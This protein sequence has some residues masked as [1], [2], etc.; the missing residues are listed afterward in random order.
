MRSAVPRIVWTETD[1]APM[2][3]TYSFLPVVKAFL[4]HGGIKVET[5]DISLAG[6]ILALFPEL[7]PE[8]KRVSDDLA[9][10]GELVSRSEANIIKLPN[11]SASVPQLKAAIR[12]LQEKGFKIPD[13][14][15]EAKTEEE[16]QLKDRYAKVLG[17]AVNPVLRQG[18]ADRR[19]PLAVKEYAK[20]YPTAMGLPLKEW[21]PNSKCHVAHMDGNDFYGNEKS[22]TVEK[23]TT[24]RIELVDESGN[25]EI[26]KENLQ[27]TEG[28]V[29]DGTFMSVKALRKFY[30]AQIE[31]A[32]RQG[33]LL[34][35]HLKATMMKVSDPVLFGHAVMVYFREVFEKY[36]DVFEEIGV[37]PNNGL[38]DLYTK[39]QKLP[40]DKRKEIEGAIDEVYKKNPELA[41]VDSRKG[42]TNLHMPNNI[43]IDAS[44]PVVIRDGGK[45]WGPDDKLHDTKAMIPDRSY[46]G[47]YKET[48]EDCKRR[49]AFDRSTMGSVSNVGL[50]A[51]KAEEYG[52]HDKTFIVPKD[53]TVRVVDENG[54]VLMEHRVEK[55]DIWRGCQA[56]DIAIKDWVG[57]AVRRARATGDPAVFWLDEKRAH[58]REIIR[59]V[60]KYLSEFDTNGLEIHIMPPVEAI[61]FSI[62]RIREGKNTISVTGNVLRDYLTDL[63][64]ILEIGTSAKMLSIVPLLAGG[65]LFETG[66]GGSA[67]K[68]VQ[69]LLEEGHLRWDSL[70]EFTALGAS[71]EFIYEKYGNKR[72]KLLANALDKAVGMLLENKKWPSRKVGELDNRGE[73]YYLTMYWAR[74]LSE[75]SEDEELRNTFSRV[76]AELSENEEK[77]NEEM[78]VAQG[79]PVD[80]GGYYYPDK[81]KT[82]RVMR[83]SETFNRIVDSI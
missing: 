39:I 83:P 71:L 54:N 65:G 5:R 55:G 1:E 37:N 15:E 29:F 6:R 62:D 69:Q 3:A 17:S 78:L 8:D 38:S 31:D 63:F 45:M 35:L 36:G 28:E 2:L 61:R 33:V 75:Q 81:E 13:Y 66:A 51:M 46:A 53:G 34:S 42:I 44:M 41:M 59:K 26:L 64:P 23:R 47:I 9:Y 76:A 48:I 18:N 11:I 12:E 10:L 79:S 22:I 7:L 73:H 77:I 25:V 32:K 60:R 72:V 67:P 4:K 19:A 58:D 70:G 82:A 50:M 68:H 43:I 57:L 56:K 49:G 24:V 80:I 74:A 21:D 14:P 52:S 27:L 40:G 16:K 20:K 30:E